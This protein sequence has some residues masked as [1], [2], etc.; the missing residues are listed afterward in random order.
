MNII[1]F[2]EKQ[3]C[4]TGF[5]FFKND[6]RYLHIKKIL[7]LKIGDEF[8]AGIINGVIGKAV[9]LEFTEEKIVFSFSEKK[10]PSPLFPVNLLLGF[11]RP[12]QLKR[13]LRDVSSLGVLQISLVASELGEKSYLNSDLAKKSEIDKIL[14]DGCS[15]AGSTLI[16]KVEI[17]KSVKHF[18][19]V[20]KLNDTAS[21]IL[22]DIGKDC[23]SISEIPDKHNF[24]CAA[25]GS[26]R[27]WSQNERSIFLQNGFIKC[28][29]GNRILRTETATTAGISLVLNS[30]GFWN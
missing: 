14:V 20:I 10:Q 26:E 5:C 11:P 15:Q 27:G 21:K 12:I 1:L 25:I 4:N 17:Y 24:V 7:K 2:S 30:F 23:M 13:I 22:F 18:F 16:P 3:K 8:K 6:A 29:I 28:S 9:I 19:E